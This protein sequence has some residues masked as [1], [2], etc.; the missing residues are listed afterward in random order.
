MKVGD[1]V[2]YVN[3]F[4]LQQKTGV[5]VKIVKEGTGPFG[6]NVYQILQVDSF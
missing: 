5:I 4:D 1:L 3:A 6:M 2:T